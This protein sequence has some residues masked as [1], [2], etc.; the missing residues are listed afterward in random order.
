MKYIR[1]LL[2]WGSWAL[3][4]ITLFLHLLFPTDALHRYA[5][6][7]I[8]H[9]NAELS[10]SIGQMHLAFP[11]RLKL[12]EVTLTR[13][14]QVLLQIPRAELTP[15][16]HFN[17]LAP[18]SLGLKAEMAGG[19]ITGH[20]APL[21]FHSPG[22]KAQLQGIQIEQLDILQD[23]LARALEVEARGV[24]NGQIVMETLTPDATIQV[25]LDLHNLHVALELPLLGSEAFHF[26][27]GTLH[28][29]TQGPILKLEEALLLG[30]QADLQFQGHLL[31]RAPV[32]QSQTDLQ[33][34]LKLHPVY[35]ASL[36]ERLPP[37]WLPAPAAGQNHYS[38]QLQGTLQQPRLIFR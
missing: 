29:L 20:L 6:A 2:W 25:E 13:L 32:L 30:E 12:T 31:L 7:R 33:G 11:F 18:L 36:R 37:G 22:L 5:Q 10:L 17:L 16:L 1:A 8:R 38:W 34:R 24:L 9:S 26:R 3:A 15:V 19:K 28:I 21:L 4:L 14:Q 27:H 35:A 23:N